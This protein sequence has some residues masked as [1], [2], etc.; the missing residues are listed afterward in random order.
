ML[1]CLEKEPTIG[2][3]TVPD[4]A[5]AAVPDEAPAAVP[6]EASAT[7]SHEAAAAVSH[8]AAA[9]V[10]TGVSCVRMC[11]RCLGI[12]FGVDVSVSVLMN[13]RTC[14]FDFCERQNSENATRAVS[15]YMLDYLRR[16]LVRGIS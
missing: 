14:W 16:V 8:K 4:E 2:A 1:E 9:A 11:A 3:A 13:H 15:I 5:A 10:P 7:V 12:Y 6:D